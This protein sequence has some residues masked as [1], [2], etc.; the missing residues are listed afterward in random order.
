MAKCIINR[1]KNVHGLEVE[2]LKYIGWS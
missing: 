2:K 1:F